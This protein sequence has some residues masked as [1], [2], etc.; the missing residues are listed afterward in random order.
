[1][2]ITASG[3]VGVVLAVPGADAGRGCPRRRVFRL[4]GVPH[5]DRAA[6]DGG[7][8]AASPAV[9]R[10]RRVPVAGQSEG[11]R[12]D[13]GALFRLRA[14]TRRPRARTSPLKI[15]VLTGDHRRGQPG[16]AL[17][18]CCADALLSRARHEPRHQRGVCRPPRRVRR[19]RAAGLSVPDSA[20][21]GA[22]RGCGRGCLA[23]A[24]RGG[25]DPLQDACISPRAWGRL[26]PSW[27]GNSDERDVAARAHC[28]ERRVAAA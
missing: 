9:L 27:R 20:T 6:P 25:S 28:R 10:R 7:R 15:V 3:V 19:L 4:S 21:R 17:R 1:M 8:R 24:S 13:G 16:M 14:G 18:R 23:I 5:R 2:G 11:L 26:F 22:G 12:G